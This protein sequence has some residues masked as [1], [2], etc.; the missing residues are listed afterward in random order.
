MASNTDDAKA[1]L[2]NQIAELKKEILG[3]RKSL[4][5][6]SAEFIDGMRDQAGDAYDDASKHAGKVARQVSNQAQ[7]LSATARENPGTTTAVL[8]LAA[9]IGFILGVCVGQAGQENNSRRGWR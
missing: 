6:R 1:I 9:A 5:S 4:S 8:G 7:A 2:E 3:L